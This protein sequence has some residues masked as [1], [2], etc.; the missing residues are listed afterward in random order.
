MIDYDYIG[1]LSPTANLHKC[2]EYQHVKLAQQIIEK[3]DSETYK[4]Y[5]ETLLDAGWVKISVTRP[6]KLYY[7]DFNRFLTTF[8]KKWIKDIFQDIKDDI[9]DISLWYLEE[10]KVFD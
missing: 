1:W 3:C 9:S 8:Q 10:E 4:P 5:D 6:S 7:I 2:R